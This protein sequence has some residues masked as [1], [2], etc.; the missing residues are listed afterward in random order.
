MNCKKCNVALLWLAGALLA[1]SVLFPNG[2]STSFFSKPVAPVAP[3]APKATDAALLEILKAATPED[4]ARIN[5]VYT[6]LET[7]LARDAGKLVTTSEQWV[8]LQAR[9]LRLAIDTPGKYKGLDEAIEAVFL[10]TV[11]TDD[12]LPNNAETQKKLMAACD[13]IANSA[14]R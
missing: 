7:V 6:A 11:G 8:E 5:G 12:V 2:P 14:T 1:A 13:I 3:A 9:T 10:K 4:L